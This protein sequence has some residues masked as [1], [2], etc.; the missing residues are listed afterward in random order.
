[1]FKLKSHSKIVECITQMLVDT[2]YKLPFYAQYNLMINFQELNS[3]PTCGVNVTRKGMNFYYNTE[4]LNKLPQ[5]EVNF[6]DIHEIFHLLFNHPKRTV[7]GRYD[8]H[9][10]NIAQDMLINSIIWSDINHGFV[11]IPKDEKGRNMA[12][13][14][15]NF[16]ILPYNFSL[17]Y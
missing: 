5:E 1:M 8:P 2:K 13:S 17:E 10:A 14:L 7:T 12:L 3:I 6:I 11:Q 16:P 15:H 9:L 4:F